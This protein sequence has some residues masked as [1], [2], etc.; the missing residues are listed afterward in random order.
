MVRVGCH[1]SGQLAELWSVRSI[2]FDYTNKPMSKE[3]EKRH[4]WKLSHEIIESAFLEVPTQP[5]FTSL[6]SKSDC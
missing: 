3:K 6:W 4:F 1:S 5:V 2:V